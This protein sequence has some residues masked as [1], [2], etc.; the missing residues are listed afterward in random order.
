MCGLSDLTE[1]N[2]YVLTFQKK[3]RF[4]KA[5]P[6]FKPIQGELIA[7]KG[8]SPE[9]IYQFSD[10]GPEVFDIK[11]QREKVPKFIKHILCIAYLCTVM[12]MYVVV[13]LS[14]SVMSLV[15]V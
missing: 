11:A 1:R 5:I 9:K 3:D 12:L 4:I 7:H 6:A 13:V 10:E 14:R 8:E 15:V 2:T